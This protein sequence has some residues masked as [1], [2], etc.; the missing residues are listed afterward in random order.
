MTFV[1][2][3]IYVNWCGF[4]PWKIA[5]HDCFIIDIIPG[6]L[7]S[8]DDAGTVN[9]REILTNKELPSECDSE[10]SNVMAEEKPLPTDI[11]STYVLKFK[12]VF[13]CRLCPRIICLTEDTLRNHLQSKVPHFFLWWLNMLLLSLLFPLL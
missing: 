6:Q 13:K 4:I 10:K 11:P 8:E 3:A 12:S 9:E 5:F 7:F 1:L 2:P